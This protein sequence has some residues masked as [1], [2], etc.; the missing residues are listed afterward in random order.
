MAENSLGFM[1]GTNLQN[2]KTNKSHGEQIKRYPCLDSSQSNYR[3]LKKKEK[4]GKSQKGNIP[5]NEYQLR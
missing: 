1:K 4:T 2:R 5:P 3:P